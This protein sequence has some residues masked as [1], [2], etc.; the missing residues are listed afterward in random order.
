ME[1][2]QIKPRSHAVEH[3]TIIIMLVL[4]LYII[5]N[6]LNSPVSVTREGKVLLPTTALTISP[7]THVLSIH[8]ASTSANKH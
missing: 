1:T 4:F 6:V 3:A 5:N 2:V 7:K 8:T